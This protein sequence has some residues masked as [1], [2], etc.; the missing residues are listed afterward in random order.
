MHQ[1]HKEA[2]ESALALQAFLH[3]PAVVLGIGTLVHRAPLGRSVQRPDVAQ[4][5]AIRLD[6]RRNDHA[7]ATSGAHRKA[8]ARTLATLWDAI[9]R[10]ADLYPSDY[11]AFDRSTRDR[12][13]QPLVQRP[14]RR[15]RASKNL[16]S[17]S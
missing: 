8:G 10:L 7:G 15:S 1:R 11:I 13:L 14:P 9:K 4:L 3:S 6:L 17:H 2:L 16:D 12:R 5:K